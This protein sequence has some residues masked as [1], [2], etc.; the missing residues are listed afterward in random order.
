MAGALQSAVEPPPDPVK[1]SN[2]ERSS[3]IA[4][5]ESLVAE[6]TPLGI[7][8]D[9]EEV[10]ERMGPPEGVMSVGNRRRMAY[11][12]GHIVVADGKVVAIE[13]VPAEWLAAP[14][15]QAY[16]DYQ[17][18]LGMVYYRGKWMSVEESWQL[19]DKTKTAQELT[20]QRITRGRIESDKRRQQ[21]A[22]Q[23]SALLDFRQNG[24]RI[25]REELIA[26][27][28]VTVVDFYADWCGP[29][30]TIAPYLH[31]LA[32]D[33]EVVVRKV[34]IVNW[35]SPVAQQWKL[36]S[37]PNMRVYDRQGQPVGKPTHDLNEIMRQID[38][39]KRQ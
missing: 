24:A 30:K 34:D 10:L 20:G 7:G 28:K 19:F 38:L 27:G 31:N 36:R 35:R 21:H 18:A 15:R 12:E 16:E 33:P 26:P 17:R 13:D 9:E 25:T 22:R 6:S 5:Y 32:T 23:Q 3:M 29:C 39:A 11:G 2:K 37:I 1:L 8:S 4:I 14:N